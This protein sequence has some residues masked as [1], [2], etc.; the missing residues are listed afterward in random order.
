MPEGPR[1]THYGRTGLLEKG[2]ETMPTI[3]VTIRSLLKFGS[4]YTPIS[5][6]SPAGRLAAWLRY[7]MITLLSPGLISTPLGP[8]SAH[9]HSPGP[10][11]A[12]PAP[13]LAHLKGV[14]GV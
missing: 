10:G 3:F 2:G 13:S 6:Y 8:R 5:A 14:S 4:R 9:A 1:S 12:A 7:P 11:L